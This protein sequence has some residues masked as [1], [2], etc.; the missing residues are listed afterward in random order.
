MSAK[1]LITLSQPVRQPTDLSVSHPAQ[2]AWPIL[3][4]IHKSFGI[5]RILLKS[6]KTTE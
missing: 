5:L 6:N 1:Q 4:P 3:E 2:L